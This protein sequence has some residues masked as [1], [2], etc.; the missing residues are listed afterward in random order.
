MRKLE[1]L[2]ELM[3]ELDSLTASSEMILSRR[4][5]V[6]PLDGL[7]L[8]AF[9][10]HFR[11]VWDFFNPPARKKVKTDVDARDYV[12]D[13]V[14]I[15]PP[16]RPAEIRKWLNVMLAHLTE[17]RADPDYKVGEISMDDISRMTEHIQHLFLK[18][19]EQLDDAQ[20]K[21][22]VN[23]LKRKFKGY[24]SLLGDFL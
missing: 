24:R 19:Y 20:K 14:P 17:H 12:A 18:F 3:F 16:R 2:G 22:L 8:E 6:P 5:R 13:W 7:L 21:S 15:D 10:L 4:H 1:M 23:P 9:C 11:I